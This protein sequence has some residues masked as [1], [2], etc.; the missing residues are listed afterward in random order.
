MKEALS[1]SESPVLTRV[2]WCKIPEDTILQVCMAYGILHYS[3]SI[4]Y[5]TAKM[6]KIKS[7]RDFSCV[8]YMGKVV[9]LLTGYYEAV[10]EGRGTATYTILILELNGVEQSDS[11]SSTSTLGKEFPKSM[12][13]EDGWTT[14]GL[15]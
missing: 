6:D 1:S 11:Y 13:W 4:K 8:Q 7:L 10:L 2:T 15:E 9:H 12:R 5:K 3:L 14:A